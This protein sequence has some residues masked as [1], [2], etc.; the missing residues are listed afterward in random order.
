[1]AEHK[2]GSMDVKAQEETF[3]GF[4]TLTVRS[5]IAIIVLLILMAL[6]NG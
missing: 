5:V 4:V 1:M 3:N 6:I 2:H